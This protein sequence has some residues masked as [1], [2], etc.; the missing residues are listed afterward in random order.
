MASTGRDGVSPDWHLAQVNVG[1]LVAPKGD[2]RVAP[3]FEA[4]DRVNALADAWPGFLWRLK[5]E[6]GNA[7]EIKPTSDPLF[8]VNMSLW[9][10]AES[11]FAYVY[12]SGHA[13]EM[14]RRREYFERFSGAHLALWWVPAGH[15]P[16]VDEAL[17]RLWRLDRYGPTAEAF[18]FKARFPTPG[19]PDAPVDMQPD[20]WCVGRA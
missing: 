7:T 19:R 8:I 13:P 20:P 9:R 6:S 3:F 4:L 14:G 15:I 11:L 5:D 1:R 18:T 17:S 2:A 16:T 10:D 12:R